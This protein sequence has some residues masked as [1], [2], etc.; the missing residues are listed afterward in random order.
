MMLCAGLEPVLEQVTS[1]GIEIPEHGS[2]S[3]FSFEQ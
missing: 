3:E 1:N 2:G